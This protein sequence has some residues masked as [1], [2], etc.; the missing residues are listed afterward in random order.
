MRDGRGR[1]SR[2]YPGPAMR[3]TGGTYEDLKTGDRIGPYR[4]DEVLGEGGMGIVSRAV[5]DPDGDVVALKVLRRELSHDYTYRRRL[6]HEARAA[7]EVR[8]RHMVPVLDAGEEAERS[9]LAVSFVSGRTLEQRIHSEGPLPLADAVRL[10]AQ[11]AT[12]VGPPSP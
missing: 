5:R 9:Y 10:L 7:G 6:I 4:L 8:H 3:G 12:G 2:R 1:V 11:V